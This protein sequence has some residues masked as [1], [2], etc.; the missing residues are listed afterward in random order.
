MTKN[1]SLFFV[2]LLLVLVCAGA[3]PAAEVDT[4]SAGGMKITADS[5][6]YD[7][8]TETYEAVGKVRIDWSGMI[9]FADEVS[10]NQS[11]N[12]ANARGNILFR[13]GEDTLEAER[14]SLDLGTER[15]EISKGRLF[16]TQGN[17]R[18]SGDLLRKTGENDYHVKNGFFTTCDGDV[19]SW[20]F[21]AAELDV[22]RG[23]YAVGRHAFFYI[24]D[25]PVLYF[26]YIIYPVKEERQSGFLLPRPGRSTKRGFFLEIPYYLVIGPSQDATFYLD[27][28]TKRGA[29]VGAQYRYLLSAGGAESSTP[30]LSTIQRWTC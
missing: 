1:L 15:G 24:R 17:F 21:S 11:D 3:L 18:L 27:I 19:P 5:I 2:S 9:M 10:L 13:K 16:L 7:K 22:T 12:L 20:K 14:F 28:Q 25:V 29:G 6:T 8:K 4:A 26:P 23:E 30:T